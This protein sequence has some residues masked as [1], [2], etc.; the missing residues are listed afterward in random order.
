M[1]WDDV[2]MEVVSAPMNTRQPPMSNPKE[3][4]RQN[5]RVLPESRCLNL[6]GPIASLNYLYRARR[7]TP[8][9]LWTANGTGLLSALGKARRQ[10]PSIQYV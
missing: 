9:V 10:Q 1:A 7:V 2:V 8:E 6:D 5:R 4:R 3:E